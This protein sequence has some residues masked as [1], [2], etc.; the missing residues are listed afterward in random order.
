MKKIEA[1]MEFCNSCVHFGYCM[2]YWG[3]ECKR[4]GGNKTP[5]MKPARSRETVGVEAQVM[6]ISLNEPEALRVVSQKTSD[7]KP[8]N[9]KNEV[10][11]KIAGIFE[12]IRTRVVNW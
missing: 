10:I 6:Q 4:Q 1:G 9:N 3:V 7:R 8:N 2:I 11:K 5:K 12:P